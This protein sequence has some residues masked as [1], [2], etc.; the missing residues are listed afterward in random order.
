[1]A[2]TNIHMLSVLYCDSSI[3]ID[4]PCSQT[5]SYIIRYEPQQ[6]ELYVDTTTTTTPTTASRGDVR[7]LQHVTFSTVGTGH[8]PG[9][10]ASTYNNH[11]LFALLHDE[12]RRHRLY[13]QINTINTLGHEAARTRPTLLVQLG[14]TYTEAL[15]YKGASAT[16]INEKTYAQVV[17]ED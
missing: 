9:S 2:P 4:N 11:H 3:T 10:S 13:G 7:R 16:I 15:V 1:M 12:R 8:S 5:T 6:W 17:E 14:R